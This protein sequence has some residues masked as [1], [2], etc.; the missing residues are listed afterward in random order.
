MF[1]RNR[2]VTIFSMSALDV[3]FGALGAFMII[4]V[5]L[6]PLQG[7]LAEQQRYHRQVL[8]IAQWQ[9]EGAD[10]DLWLETP[11]GEFLGP[12][13]ATMAPAAVFQTRDAVGPG[14]ES[15]SQVGS[16]DGVYRVIVQLVSLGAARA[17]VPVKLTMIVRAQDE[18]GGPGAY[19]VI[20]LG[21]ASLGRVGELRT[22]ARVDVALNDPSS[23]LIRSVDYP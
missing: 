23:A 17:P 20:D 13:P 19:A 10:V 12:K 16:A 1:R 6:F 14:Q 4:M 7:E 3:I 5:A 9:K 22:W 2:E 21:S 8:V 18:E 15:T 11:S